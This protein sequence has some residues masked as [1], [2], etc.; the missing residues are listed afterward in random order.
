MGRCPLNP[1]VTRFVLI[2]A[3]AVVY[4]QKPPTPTPTPPPPPVSPTRPVGTTNPNNLPNSTTNNP[5]SIN[6]QPINR[7][8]YLSG[9]VVLQDGTPPARSRED[10][11]RPVVKS[12]PRT[13]GYTDS[14]GRFQF[15]VD[16]LV[17]VEQDASD[18]VSRMSMAGRPSN[19]MAARGN[20]AGCDLRAVLPG[21][22]SGT[23]NLTNHNEFDSSDVGTI[24]LRRIG[25]VDGTTISMTSLH[26]PKDALKAY[27]KGR[28]LLKKEKSD[29][30]EKNFQKA[31]DVYPQYAAAWYQLGLLQTR[32]QM[33]Q[34]QMSFNKAIEA[35]PKFVSPYLSLTM[36]QVQ[37]KNWQKAIELSDAV[38]KLN[39]GT[40]S[41][42]CISSRPWRSTTIKRMPLRRR[43]CG[44]PSNSTFAM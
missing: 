4:A 35:D 32:S 28:E 21:F 15:Q 8:I 11:T 25:N 44:R 5:N 34:A 22:V 18:P 27:E 2:A 43:P 19:S 26:A 40:I 23:I 42:R 1:A 17:G 41:P 14:K 33:E 7:P 38:I 39:V 31:V 36:I 20:L 6:T 12:N 9:K 16:S 3:A 24:I 10:R 13:Q 30:A 29:E 37:S